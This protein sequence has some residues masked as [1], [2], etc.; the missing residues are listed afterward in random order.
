[1]ECLWKGLV[2]FSFQKILEWH[3]CAVHLL[4][5]YS[6]SAQ[7]RVC[8]A[9]MASFLENLC[10]D[11][12]YQNLVVMKECMCLGHMELWVLYLLAHTCYWWV[13]LNTA[14]LMNCT[15]SIKKSINSVCTFWVVGW[16]GVHVG[17][18]ELPVGDLVRYDRG[19][20]VPW[21]SANANIGATACHRQLTI[22]LGCVAAHGASGIH[23][24]LRPLTMDTASW[25]SQTGSFARPGCTGCT[26]WNLGSPS[27]WRLWRPSNS[28]C[29]RNSSTG[30]WS[31]CGHLWWLLHSLPPS[32]F[33]L[34]S[35]I[36]GPRSRSK[37]LKCKPQAASRKPQAASR[38]NWGAPWQPFTW[39]WKRTAGTWLWKWPAFCRGSLWL[40]KPNFWIKY[41]DHLPQRLM[42]NCAQ[43][44]CQGCLALE[45]QTSFN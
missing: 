27:P 34:F 29:R 3:K 22:A 5:H 20:L 13:S 43:E 45:D 39:P 2:H 4:S 10:R 14:G 32:P 28:S 17:P 36:L 16:G 41:R 18:L 38:S 25:H 40:G 33:P 9:W 44:F 26:K 30:H 31:S 1:M 12:L 15:T 21:K 42:L 35:F 8:V 24:L 11:E 7:A 6:A 23:V 19:S 37:C